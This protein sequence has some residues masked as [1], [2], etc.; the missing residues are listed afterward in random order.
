MTKCIV[1]A[2]GGHAREIAAY[3]LDDLGTSDRFVGAFDD[4]FS[5]PIPWHGSHLIG[6]INDL[7]AFCASHPEVSYIIAVGNNS[8][9]KKIALRIEAMAIPNLAPFTVRH[10]SAWT[11]HAV[12]VGE[13]SLLAPNSIV[14]T[15]AKIGRHCI[16]NVKAS[17]S[18]DCEIG[19]FCNINPNATLCG[20]VK[21][22]EGCY[23]GAGATIIEKRKIGAWTTIGAGAVVTQDLPDGVT[24]VGIPARIIKHSPLPARF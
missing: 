16:L 23:V 21:L 13:G 4:A 20:D 11:G 9:R 19:D 6:A 18:H 8:I 17:V 10:S 1:I 24:A 14:T 5:E 12:S 22:G 7:P 15:A 3:L 2:A